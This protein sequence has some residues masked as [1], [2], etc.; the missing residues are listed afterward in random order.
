MPGDGFL[1][2]MRMIIKPDRPLTIRK[3]RPMALCA[4]DVAVLGIP[5]PCTRVRSSYR[6]WISPDSRYALVGIRLIRE[7]PAR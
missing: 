1:I 3:A 2:G 5:G 4:Y 6:N 7:L